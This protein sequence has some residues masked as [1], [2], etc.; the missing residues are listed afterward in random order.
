MIGLVRLRTFALVLWPLLALPI[1]GWGVCNQCPPERCDVADAP[2]PVVCPDNAIFCV[3]QEIDWADEIC[4]K[5]CDSNYTPPAS[6]WNLCGEVDVDF[7]ADPG[8][9]LDG[10]CATFTMQGPAHHTTP[11]GKIVFDEP[12]T[13]TV[14]ATVWDLGAPGCHDGE[15]DPLQT[16][17]SAAVDYYVIGSTKKPPVSCQPMVYI[18]D[19]VNPDN[20]PTTQVTAPDWDLQPSG[21]EIWW[22]IAPPT[23]A[24]VAFKTDHDAWLKC[25]AKPG[26]GATVSVRATYTLRGTTC[27]SD[28]VVID[29]ITPDRIV[30]IADPPNADPPG[31]T[32]VD[33][34]GPDVCGYRSV[35]WLQ[36]VDQ[37][38]NGW[39][40]T[41]LP[42]L[43]ISETHVPCCM[44]HKNENPP[45]ISGGG[46]ALGG[47]FWDMLGM[48]P[49][50]VPI[51]GDLHIEFQQVWV[52]NGC[53]MP[54]TCLHWYFDHGERQDGVCPGPCSGGE[55]PCGP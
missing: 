37:N 36:V 40:S 46:P 11:N 7:C 9:K 10:W 45:I 35:F 50:A 34:C 6:Y 8:K 55:M 49:F 17:P 33:Y 21:T 48:G 12:G 5:P 15:V 52:V 28:W 1:A 39:N 19:P 16:W 47:V 14:S 2:A 38:G 43:T 20:Q 18:C 25:T 13:G 23:A 3:G 29:I 4:F 51:P 53:Q 54:P 31:G 26:P 41:C 30:P 27:Y 32:T 44:N 24:K 22:E 42:T